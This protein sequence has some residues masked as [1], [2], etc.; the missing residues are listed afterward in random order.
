LFFYIPILI[1]SEFIVREL[2]NINLACQRMPTGLHN[3]VDQIRYSRSSPALFTAR[4]R[5]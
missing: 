2:D 5:Q 3:K 4:M 1:I